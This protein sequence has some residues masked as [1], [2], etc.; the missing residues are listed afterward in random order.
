[1]YFCLIIIAANK[2]TYKT[3]IMFLL[4]LLNPGK[5]KDSYNMQDMYGDSD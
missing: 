2:A 5:G 1:M 3:I 4:R